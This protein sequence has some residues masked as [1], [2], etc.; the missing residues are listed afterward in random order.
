[1]H[2]NIQVEQTKAELKKL[3][4]ACVL[5][6]LEL[7]AQCESDPELRGAVLAQCAADFFFF[8][9]YFVWTHDPRE[10]S[11]NQVI[12]L[13]PYQYQV[14]L[15]QWFI[16]NIFATIGTIVNR[17]LLVEKSR[18]M[19][20][21][22]IVLA[23]IVWLWRFHTGNC[24]IGS[25]TAP[26]VDTKG[27]L[28]TH[29]E[30]CR[31]IIRRWP[32]WMDPAG[33]DLEKDMPEM[34]IRCPDAQISG[35]PPTEEFS[36]QGR[37]MVIF[38]DEYS[39]WEC[40]E[41]AFAATSEST[42]CRLIVGTPRG[43][44]NH[45]A[46]LAQGKAPE[47]VLKKRVH[48][49]LHPIKSAG[50][51]LDEQGNPTSPWYRE[52]C[53]G[54]TPEAVAAELDIKYDT[55]TNALVF[56]EFMEGHRKQNLKPDPDRKILRIWDPGI[57]W[58]V[59]WLQVDN[60]GRVLVLH[61]LVVENAHLD[62]VAD[63][64]KRISQ[65]RFRGFTFEDCGDPAGANRVTAAQEEPEYL[66]LWANHGIEVEYLGFVEMST[67]IRVKARI[68]QIKQQLREQCLQQK[69]QKLLVDTKACPIL[70]EALSEGYRWKLDR[71]TKKPKDEV[72]EKHPYEDVVDC[73]GYGLLYKFGLAKESKSTGPVRVAKGSVK[74]NGGGSRNVS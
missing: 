55:S 53:K 5:A 42:Q 23:L 14:E 28:A 10:L 71:F 2:S 27:N 35:A 16:E 47:K 63:Q 32:R 6:R 58:A 67:K 60:Y 17:D 9:Y 26:K 39:V 38:L 44:H 72:D 56:P 62:D 73:L 61:E 30:K 54:K 1:M 57:T 59:L 20:L 19:G 11:R 68:L 18:D 21:T 65:D 49:T 40:D 34:L 22:W 13:V 41:P 25:E 33:F 50:L 7:E 51:E 70:T 74:W 15:I 69:S 12:P 64:V 45:Y 66:L 36:R 37:Y 43:P 48:W 46:R 31:F 24:L 8:C 3:Q 29:M 52:K 4:D